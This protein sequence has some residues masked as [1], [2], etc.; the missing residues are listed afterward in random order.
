[1]KDFLLT[2][3]IS[4]LMVPSI[5]MFPTFTTNDIKITSPIQYATLTFSG[6]KTINPL[7]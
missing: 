6:H 5:E 7:I 2:K 3:H 4:K 1:M